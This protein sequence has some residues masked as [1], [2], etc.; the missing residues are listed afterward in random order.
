MKTII[1]LILS[2]ISTN[3]YGDI[4]VEN[5]NSNPGN[6]WQFF[7]DQVMGGKSNGKLEFFSE[8]N[9]YF[10][11]MTG[12]VSIKNNGGFIQFRA[13]ILKKLDNNFK[14]IK[15]KVRG[16]NQNYFI[17]IRTT[18]SVLPWQYYDKEFFASNEW[19]E[20]ELNFSDFKKSSTFMRKKFKASSIKTIG[21]VAYG[22][23]HKAKIEV[24]EISIY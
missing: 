1:V 11:R 15:L 9:N 5:F 17:H 18:G 7:T 2:L 16:N 22:R 14:G 24:S 13:D 19:N 21:I 23:E 10:A 12:D 4:V 3:V 20:V 6:R 8:E